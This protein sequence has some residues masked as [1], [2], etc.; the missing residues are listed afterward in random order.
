MNE[1][2]PL[3][4]FL[5][6]S[7]KIV[8]QRHLLAF[9]KKLKIHTKCRWTDNFR[10]FRNRKI[11]RWCV[12]ILGYGQCT[13]SSMN[14]IR[15]AKNSYP[16]EFHVLL[17]Q[18]VCLINSSLRWFIYSAS[19]NSPSCWWTFTFLRLGRKKWLCFAVLLLIY[20]RSIYGKNKQFSSRFL[21]LMAHLLSVTT[22]SGLLSPLAY[23]FSSL[24]NCIN[25]V[26]VHLQLAYTRDGSREVFI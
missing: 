25:A 15:R 2:C 14:P 1:A 22:Y 3:R 9:K 4:N 16:V 20:F 7:S 11:S 8:V 13:P 17:A 10:S 18:R 6:K 5:A 26:Q 12:V 19:T 24:H 21:V 23:A